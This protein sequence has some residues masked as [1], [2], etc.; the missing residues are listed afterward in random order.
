MSVLKT[1]MGVVKI[2]P[3]LLAPITAAV[4]RAIVLTMMHILVM[5]RESIS[6]SSEFNFISTSHFIQTL[7][8]VPRVLT[9]ALR[10]VTTTSAPTPAAVIL[11]IDYKLMEGLVLVSHSTMIAY[12]SISKIQCI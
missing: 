2:V 4:T 7:M 6:F 12:L 3:I 1:G 11:D 10:T 8:S 9:C 5:V